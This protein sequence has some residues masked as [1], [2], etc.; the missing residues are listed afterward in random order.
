MFIVMDVIQRLDGTLQRLD[1]ICSQLDTIRALLNRTEEG[2]S[3]T[4]HNDKR[5]DPSTKNK[6]S[7]RRE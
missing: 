5:I 6:P 2:G 1:R 7:S 3:L 4:N